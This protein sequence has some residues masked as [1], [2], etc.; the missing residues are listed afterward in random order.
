MWTRKTTWY[1]TE[2][3]ES[4]MRMMRNSLQ[5]SETSSRG[6]W[7]YWDS[8]TLRWLNHSLF[9]PSKMIINRRAVSQSIIWH[10]ERMLSPVQAVSRLSTGPSVMKCR[11]V[12]VSFTHFQDREDLLK[13]SKFLKVS[14]SLIY[15]TEAERIFGWYLVD[16]GSNNISW[17]HHQATKI[18]KSSSE[19]SIPEDPRG[20]TGV[21][22]I[23]Y[24]CSED[25]PWDKWISALWQIIY[26]RR[27][28]SLW[29]AD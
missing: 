21:E 8:S 29:W 5:S 27:Y 18:S 12:L 7:K 23:P 13:A 26:W 14:D 19:G 16:I 10:S 2:W 1:L 24:I 22:E 9:N 17:K 15:I 11:P 25:Q 28:L 6:R 4:P 3:R 20:S